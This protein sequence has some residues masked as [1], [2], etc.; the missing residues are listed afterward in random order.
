MSD[1]GRLYYGS[2][3]QKPVYKY[4]ADLFNEYYEIKFDNLETKCLVRIDKLIA[5][6]F[7]PDEKIYCLINPHWTDVKIKWKVAD[8]HIIKSKS[9]MVD[10]IQSKING[11]NPTYAGALE[12]HGFFNRNEYKD[13]INTKMAKAYFGMLRRAGEYPGY[14]DVKVCD[15]WREGQDKFNDWYLANNYYYPEPLE[16]DKDLIAY[17]AGKLYS[18]GTC[19]LLPSRLNIFFSRTDGKKGVNIWIKKRADGT[20]LYNVVGKK[21]KSFDNYLDALKYARK[22]KA[23]QIRKIVKAERKKGYMPEYLLDKMSKWAD[24]AEM[25]LIQ[26][27]EPDKKV[28]L[29]EGII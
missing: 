22:K 10:Y 20:S 2:H 21:W 23:R 4:G 26:I 18:P 5:M 25:G 8:L 9:E 15:T 12:Q 28:L 19:C 1:Y 16:L 7:R 24:L 27:W 17:G 29:E 3:W 13:G 6:V 14:E 11:I